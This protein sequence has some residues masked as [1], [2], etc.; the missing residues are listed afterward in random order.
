MGK[1]YHYDEGWN[2]AA[3]VG[4]KR[5]SHPWVFGNSNGSDCNSVWGK[6]EVEVRHD[7]CMHT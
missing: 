3:G 2:V 1:V 6:G 7:D 5:G 4:K